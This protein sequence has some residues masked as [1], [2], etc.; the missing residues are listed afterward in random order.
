[1]E[2]SERTNR[3]RLGEDWLQSRK[4]R[5]FFVLLTGISLERGVMALVQSA[6]LGRL[7]PN[8][9]LI[10]FK[11]NWLTCALKDLESYVRVIQ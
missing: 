8:I 7:Q 1:M 4:N 10:G 5:A 9:M 6:G 2:Y 11:E 3:I